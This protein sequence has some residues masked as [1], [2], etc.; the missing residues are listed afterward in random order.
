MILVEYYV[1][2]PAP[3]E[4]SKLGAAPAARSTQVHTLEHDGDHAKTETVDTD[5]ETTLQPP[6]FGSKSSKAAEFL[7]AL[8]RL[9][10]HFATFGDS[11]GLNQRPPPLPL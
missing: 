3:Q 9:H 8:G 11:A 5:A 6:D 7:H 10:E 1:A 4:I 2:M